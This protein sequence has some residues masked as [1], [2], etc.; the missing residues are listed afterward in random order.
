MMSRPLPV[1]LDFD[2]IEL[3][4]LRR[5]ECWGT[6]KVRMMVVLRSSARRAHWMG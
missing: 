5:V 2:E 6:S 1:E 4:V 3:H